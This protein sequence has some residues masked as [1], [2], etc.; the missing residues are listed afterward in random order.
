MREIDGD[1]MA[2]SREAAGVFDGKNMSLYTYCHH[3]PMIFID[4]DGNLLEPISVGVSMAIAYAGA[5]ASFK[6]VNGSNVGAMISASGA[7]IAAG[8]ITCF[9]PTDLSI[10]GAALIGAGLG[11]W[12]GQ[13]YDILSGHKNEMSYGEFG[14]ALVGAYGNGISMSLSKLA[15]ASLAAKGLLMLSKELLHEIAFASAFEL[16]SMFGELIGK[17][18]EDTYHLKLKLPELKYNPKP[19]INLLNGD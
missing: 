13:L 18:I 1:E 7:A 11:N 16:P 15:N 3:N 14:G 2:I 4:P 19:E 6:M 10:I 5:Y 12:G 17:G 9:D 8:L